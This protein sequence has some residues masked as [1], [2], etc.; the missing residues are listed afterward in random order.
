MKKVFTI[1]FLLFLSISSYSQYSSFD[2]QGLTREYLVHLPPGYS[3]AVEYP[4]VLNL[5]GLGSDAMEQQAYSAFNSVADTA[6]VIVVYPNG[7]DNQWNVAL[8]T[9]IDDVGFI[10]ALVDTMA[11]NYSID[12][13]RV[14]STGMS[15]G[16][17]MSHRLACELEHKIVAIASVTGLLAY[18]PCQ[19]ERP[20][21]VLQIHGTNDPVVPYGGTAGTI[22]HWVTHN[23]C[24]SSPEVTDLPDIDPT[25]NSTVTLSYYGLCNDSTEVLFYTINGGEHTWPGAFIHIGVTNQDINASVE[26]WN[27]FRKYT[28]RDYLGTEELIAAAGLTME[29]HPNPVSDY[30]AVSLRGLHGNTSN[31]SYSVKV[32]SITGQLVRN[33]QD[34]KAG[35]RSLLDCTGL[36]PGLYVVECS[37]GVKSIRKK[38]LVR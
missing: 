32:Y 18:F 13:A 31:R 12:M 7:V 9:G 25:D 8:N 1:I 30:A 35:E 11:A 37:Q 23:G 15:M 16:G 17:F 20:V 21:P 26:I 38:M 2:Y 34:Q 29:I 10:S 14:Y 6:G 5:H 22:D 27:F 4:L 24:P 36:T 33:L 3:Q 28:S 19:P